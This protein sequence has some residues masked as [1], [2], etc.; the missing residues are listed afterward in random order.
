MERLFVD[1]RDLN[2][3]G[4]PDLV[5]GGWWYP[6]PGDLG[7]TWTRQAIGAPLHNVA[8][9]HDFDND[10]DLDILGTNGQ[11]GGEDFSWARNDGAGT[12][13]NFDITNTATAGDFLQGVSLFQVIDGSAGGQ[14]EII[15]S[16]HNGGSGTAM[17]SVPDDP[18]TTAWPLTVLSTATNQE[19]APTGDLDGDGD[20]DI[21]L[22]T[23]WLRQETDGTF[24]TQSGITLSGGG[25]PDRVVLADLDGDGDLDL[26]V[27]SFLPQFP[28]ATSR[29]PLNLESLIWIEQT[30]PRRFK[31]HSLETLNCDHPSLEVGDYDGDGDIDLVT[32]NFAVSPKK[33]GTIDQWLT[34]FE[35]QRR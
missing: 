6:N 30:A 2:G 3:D 11:V 17:L 33:L 18:T 25:V 1:G 23:S 31:R 32:G 22:G 4:L 29:K 8:V 13:T 10:G 16:W 19:Q 12:F 27:S 28:M 34:V 15:L 9:V 24:S 20:I 14:E 35:N 26:A 5:T 7:G 21:H